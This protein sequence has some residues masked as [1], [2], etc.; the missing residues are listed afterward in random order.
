M[1]KI[2]VLFLL[3]A[4]C[5][6][7]FAGCASSL[8]SGLEEIGTKTEE[9]KEP[10]E[11]ETGEIVYP[12]TFAVGYATIDISG[13][14]SEGA[15]LDYYGGKATG[16]HD[17][18]LLTCVALWDGEEVA[19]VMTADLKKMYGNTLFN[20]SDVA[21]KS[22]DIIKNKFKIPAE[23]VILS[24]THSHS[25][26]DAGENHASNLRWQQYYYKQLPVVVE[27]ALRD[28]DVLDGAYTG[29]SIM[30]E[31]ITFVRRYYLESGKV[32]MSPAESDKPVSHES[33]ADPELRTIRFD[34]KNK[35]DVL[36][37]N[38]QTH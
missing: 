23:N 13:T 20:T 12:D 31:G 15:P 37:V 28:L 22:L 16:I 24:C 35:K 18:L 21:G 6:P 25:A 26:P 4:L 34:R 5:L 10:E 8:E 32:K 11:Q 2:I 19:L 9:Q 1:K 7:L 38:F 30:E 27:N 3:L 33:E 36:L 17:P 14:P 29:K